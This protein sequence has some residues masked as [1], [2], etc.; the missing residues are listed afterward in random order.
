[1]NIS[2]T[3][4]GQIRLRKSFW[5]CLLGLIPSS[6]TSASMLE[7]LTVY[8]ASWWMRGMQILVDIVLVTIRSLF[9]EGGGG[10]IIWHN[11]L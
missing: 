5:K 6:F 3:A 4:I 1:M 2:P 9:G 8:K 10:H 7:V 11:R